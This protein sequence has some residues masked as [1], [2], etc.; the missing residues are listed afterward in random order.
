M[1]ELIA[2]TTFEPASKDYFVL[3]LYTEEANESIQWKMP[4][5]CV[6][7]ADNCNAKLL[8]LTCRISICVLVIF[9]L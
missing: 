9:R 3:R 4:R 1:A 6:K 8:I 2:V 5:F 7:V